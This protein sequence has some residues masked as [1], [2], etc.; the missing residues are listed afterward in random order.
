MRS[1]RRA[2]DPQ[3]AVIARLNA[4]VILA[5]LER[6]RQ[7]RDRLRRVRREA[8]LVYLIT[9]VPPQLKVI[10]MDAFVHNFGA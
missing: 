8:D 4:P 7:S 6:R 10:G 2:V 5:E 3:C 1:L 9:G